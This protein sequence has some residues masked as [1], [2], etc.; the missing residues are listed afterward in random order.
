MH[1]HNLFLTFVAL[2]C[3]VLAY[4]LT[5]RIYK[6]SSQVFSV[7]AHHQG[8]VFQ[9][10]LL[11]WDGLDLLLNADEAAFFGRVRALQGYVLN[12]PESS[13]VLNSTLS[14]NV[15]QTAPETINV[16]VDP[17]TH[18]LTTTDKPA[19]A[20]H[21]FGIYKQRLTYKNSTEFLACPDRSY[22]GQYHVYWGNN[23]STTCP[24]KAQGYTVELLVQTDATV[25]YSPETNKP[26]NSTILAN[27]T[28]PILPERR[29][30]RFMF[31]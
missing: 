26:L 12:L 14:S 8:K 7:I 15:T 1:L 31:F 28:V 3:T 13:A 25:N 30:R 4:P 17:K 16:H 23:N 27:S 6:P 18:K 21:G 9:Y 5:R 10:N 19:N 11:K 29:R 20:T 2:L 24:Y 22:R